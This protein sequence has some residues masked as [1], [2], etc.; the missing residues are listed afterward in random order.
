[1]L[2]KIVEDFPND[3]LYDEHTPCISLYQPTHRCS[4]ENKQD[5]IVY[6][7]LLR[8]IEH[9][10]A[11]KYQKKTIDSIMK[12]FY[13]LKDDKDFWYKTSDSLAVLASET[14]CVVYKLPIKIKEMTVVSD[15]FHI[16]PLIRYF[17]SMEKYQ[18][19]GLSRNEFTLFQGSRNGYQKMELNP[20]VPRTM[21]E[22]L[23]EEMTEAYEARGNG[24]AG[25][26]GIF[27]GLGEKKAEIDKDT[28][29]FFRYVD[30]YIFENYSKPSKLPLI[31]VALK[32]YH[33][34]FRKISHNRY[35][36]DEGI[37]LSFES[38]ETEHLKEKALEIIK[39]IYTKKIKKLLDAYENA[40]ANMLGAD[41]IA[42]IA[43]ASFDS[44]VK[45][46]IIEADR[47][48][49]GRIDVNTGQILSGD[50]ADPEVDDVL[51]DIAELVLKNRGETVIFPNSMMPS[52][53]GIAAIYRY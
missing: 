45:V 39:P 14:N 10:L 22:V 44:R 28:E 8:D 16:K 3:I 46:V 52:A 11:Q 5:R 40:K 35:L 7:N 33:A 25:G 50:L 20:E 27:Y 12:P 29:R 18:L 15:S 43:K 26:V 6:K 34:L 42:Q 51:D 1:M 9:S 4:P 32:E 2:Y 17:Q 19:L 41:D 38:I 24:D 48:I 30:Q 31:L 47:M 49:P 36:L 37:D 21:I 23:G 13:Q 53:S